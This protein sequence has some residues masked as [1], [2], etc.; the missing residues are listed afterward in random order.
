MSFH[1][2][3][4]SRSLVDQSSHACLR[5]TTCYIDQ[6]EL[7]VIV[8]GPSFSKWRE[9]SENADTLAFRALSTRHNAPRPDCGDRDPRCAVAAGEDRQE[10]GSVPLLPPTEDGSPAARA[11]VVVTVKRCTA[12][13]RSSGGFCE[14]SMNKAPTCPVPGAPDVVPLLG[15][16]RSNRSARIPLRRRLKEKSRARTQPRRGRPSRGG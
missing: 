5:N 11:R 9:S 3:S 4:L 7:H 14:Q 12:S 1:R 2:Y 10:H 15:S 8:L 13:Y 16:G 6:C